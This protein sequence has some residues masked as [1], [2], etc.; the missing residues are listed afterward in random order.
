MFRFT[1]ETSSGSYF[2]LSSNYNYESVVLVVNEAV[3][4][5]AA[6]Q[7]VVKACGAASLHKRLICRHNIDCVYS[8]EHNRI[9]I[10]VLA[11]HEIGP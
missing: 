11:K 6:Y 8:D 1:Q 4:V 2:V 7:A 9:I 10:L 3:K 5:T